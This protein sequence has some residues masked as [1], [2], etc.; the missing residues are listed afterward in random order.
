MK[1]LTL[2]FF[3]FLLTFTFSCSQKGGNEKINI[4]GTYN[5]D[6]TNPDGTKY[7]GTCLI[8]SSDG[9]YALNWDIAGK[10]YGGTGPL[11]GSTLTIDFGD[12]NPVIYA[13]SDNGKTL[14]GTW[15]GG[16]AS[17]MLTLK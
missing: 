6:G 8:T 2:L 1:N 13:V 3:V 16:K 10:K 11:S 14:S 9:V 12:T 17:E 5:V 7:L 15:G 4:G